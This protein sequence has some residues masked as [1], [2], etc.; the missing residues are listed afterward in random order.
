MNQN[1]VLLA[2]S[3]CKNKEFDLVKWLSM[4]LHKIYITTQYKTN[5][6]TV[7]RSKKFK[8]YSI[9]KAEWLY[10]VAVKCVITPGELGLH[11]LNMALRSY[12]EQRE[13]F[14]LSEWSEGVIIFE[15]G[16]NNSA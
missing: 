4:C 11:P 14:L 2:K 3:I 5:S 10:T 6:A 15:L 9:Y 13:D 16:I 7:Q 1:Q 8:T 12:S